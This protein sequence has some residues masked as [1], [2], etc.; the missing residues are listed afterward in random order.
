MQ[1]EDSVDNV[2]EVFF[3]IRKIK[4]VTLL[5][6][7]R[8]QHYI[9]DGFSDEP[10]LIAVDVKQKRSRC[11][12]LFHPSVCFVYII[13]DAKPVCE[14]IVPRSSVDENEVLDF[15]CR[16]AYRWHSIDQVSNVVPKIN[17]SFGWVKDSQ[18][19]VTKVLSSSLQSTGSESEE[20]NTTVSGA[21]KPVIPAQKCT[22]TF[23]FARGTH[24]EYSY[25]LNPVSY[26]CS[27]DPIPVRCKCSLTL[28]LEYIILCNYVLR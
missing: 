22:I 13:S 4:C 20:A 15:T 26:T 10:G 21:M 6:L 8:C 3:L 9:A 7:A 23:T 2:L 14:P 12:S 19:H 5:L 17:V 16:M 28:N 24:Y 25:A 27:S 18:Q 11:W 1:W